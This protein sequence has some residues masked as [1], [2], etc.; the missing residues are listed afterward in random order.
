[1]IQGTHIGE[2]G[3]V[4]AVVGRR[5]ASRSFGEQ[6]AYEMMPL[7]ELAFRIVTNADTAALAELH[8]RAAPPGP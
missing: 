8:T 5:M 2:S 3:T 1:M 7:G 6:R 4:D